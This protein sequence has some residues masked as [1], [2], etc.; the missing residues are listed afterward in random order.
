MNNE[1]EI[2]RKAVQNDLERS[3]N[4]GMVDTDD[5]IG[6]TVLTGTPANFAARNYFVD[7]LVTAG[8]DVSVD[9]VGH[10]QNVMTLLTQL[11][12]AVISTPFL[13]VGYS[14]D[15]SVSTLRWKQFALLNEAL[16]RLTAR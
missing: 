15:H 10:R 16:R 8:L 5:G 13:R 12:Q 6:R 3:A 14:T 1:L 9:A 11:P 4:F 7:Q 2:D